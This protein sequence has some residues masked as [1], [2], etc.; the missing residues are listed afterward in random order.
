MTIEFDQHRGQ[1]VGSLIRLSGRVLGMN[2]SVEV[3]ER[4]PPRRKVWQTVGSPRL[5]VIGHYRMGFEIASQGK[6]SLLHVFIDYSLPPSGVSR[7]LG[8]LFGGFYAKWCVGQMVRDTAEYFR[9]HSTD[10]VVR[11]VWS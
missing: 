9:Q 4:I 8:W 11:A 2:L 7:C 1:T 10:E 5:L 3:V 6:R